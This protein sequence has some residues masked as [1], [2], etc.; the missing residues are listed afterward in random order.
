MSRNPKTIEVNRSVASALEL[1]ERHAITV[2]PVTTSRGE[3]LGILH[4]HDLLGK[5]HIQFT[6]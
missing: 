1:M 5:G 4:L 6:L 3:L 2:L